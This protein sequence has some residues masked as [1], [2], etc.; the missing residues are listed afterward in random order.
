MRASPRESSARR[1]PR[2]AAAAAAITAAHPRALSRGLV[3][4]LSSGD[5]APRRHDASTRCAV[6]LAEERIF[7][8]SVLGSKSRCSRKARAAAGLSLRQAVRSL[9]I[10]A[11][12]R[13]D[14]CARPADRG[15]FRHHGL[16]LCRDTGHRG[17]GGPVATTA[18][19]P[20][21]GFDGCARRQVAGALRDPEP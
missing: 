5:R 8:E 2:S 9:Q 13:C 7:E 3:D 19:P 1:S 16:G 18:T 15:T 20:P 12:I 17:I 21:F 4:R 14:G 10:C 6:E 11:S